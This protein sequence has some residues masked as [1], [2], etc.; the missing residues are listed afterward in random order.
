MSTR[1]T[2]TSIQ[3]HVFAG[4]ACP[5]FKGELAQENGGLVCATCQVT[6]PIVDGIPDFIS[7]DLTQSASPVLRSFRLIDWLGRVYESRWW[8]PLVLNLYAGVRS[9]T[10]AELVRVV[11]EMVQTN[12][13]LLLDVACGPGTLGR[14][15]VSPAQEMYG[16]DI[17]RGMLQSG[18]AL[19]R[20][21]QQDNMHLARAKVEAL[22]FQEAIFDAAICGGALHLFQDTLLALR[23]IARTVRRGA[24]LA[25]TTFIAGDGG[26]LK[27]R[28]V[29]EH[30]ISDHGV[31]VFELPELEGYLAEAGFDSF[32]PRLFGSLVIFRAVRK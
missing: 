6:Y 23:E 2:G 16:I 21:E 17:S 26:I 31:H 24:P 15:V 25:V 13:E 4:Y 1:E 18:L 19:A 20:R 30:V 11:A 14:R 7:E 29:R 10:L 27:F 22:P 8:Y 32:S 28:R 5:S 9:T 3:N 12:G